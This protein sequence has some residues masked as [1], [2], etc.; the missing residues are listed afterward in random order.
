MIKRIAQAWGFASILLLPNYV[1]M[2]SSAGDAR[3]RFP[4]P[5]TKIALAHLTDIVI[6]A[7]VFGFGMAWL[8]GLKRW[9]TIRWYLM[10]IMPIF[11]FIRN[12]D[13]F[14]FD[15]EPAAVLRVSLVWVAIALVL[16]R[17][18]TP[19]AHRI[20]TF[21]SSL[22]AGFGIFGLVM[23]GQLVRAAVWRPG[24]Q[25]FS[26]PIASP[27]ASKP[28]VVW[29]L[30]DELAYRHTFED[31]NPSLNLTNF[32]RL[33]SE[34]TL[35]TDMTPIAYRTT[36]AVP[37]LMLGR[38]V[39]DVEY[40]Q[41]NE[42]LIRTT[43]QRRWQDFDANASLFGIAKQQGVTTS[44]VGW[45]I[46]YCP[47]F[48]KVATQCYWSNDDA[49]DRG[50]T[51]LDA[52]FAENVWLPLRILVEHFV[53]PPS[54]WRDI[55]IRNAEGHIASVRDLSQHALDTL[56]SSQADVIYIHLP[57]PHPP[58]FWNRKTG[59]YAI[60]GSYLDSLDY[61][62]RLL[63]EML[64]VLEKQPRWGAT[65]LIVQGD[66][67]WR[68]GMWRSLPG[69]NRE[70]ERLYSKNSWDPRPVL[71]IH[72]AGQHDPKT[73]AD[74][75]SMMFVHEEVAAQIQAIAQSAAK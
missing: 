64:D 30:F 55:T 25:T 2:T 40:T 44:I 57:A 61:S 39:T 4:T 41:H 49:Q 22:L 17:S 5:L 31:R 6:V 70:D 62:D 28:R 56:G 42:Y 38:E 7:A 29:I 32:D 12:L 16:V 74:P 75:T 50:P 48:A 73:V 9:H 34:S 11:L 15:M 72:A 24:P 51:W 58:G 14:P 13:V 68:T 71:L 46:A 47:I 69:W 8:R 33:R 21:G 26:A 36:H 37:S 60:G 43:D 66:H 67:S 63:G 19:I 35:Y 10:G 18:L 1:D 23:G 54:A 52:S 53:W 20:R 45:Y 65:T 59:Q 3:M 27:P